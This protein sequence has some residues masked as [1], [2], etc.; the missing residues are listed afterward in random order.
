MHRLSLI[1]AGIRR[2]LTTRALALLAGAVLMTFV[3]GSAEAGD[4]S[5]RRIIGFS[6][7]GAYFAFEQYGVLDGADAHP[8]W[9]EIAVIDTQ[10][11]EVVG[12]KPIAVIDEKN[13]VKQARA[14]AAAQAAPLLAK[15]AI[16]L[17]GV[18]IERDRFTLPDD[19]IT[20]E[21]VARVETASERLLGAIQLE[22]ILAD[23]AKDCSA[24]FGDKAPPGDKKGKALGFRLSVEDKDGK[25]LKILREDKSVPEALNCPTSYSLS[26]AYQFK[27]NGK[28]AVLAVLVQSF[29]KGY[30]GPD[31]RFIAVVGQIPDEAI[32]ANKEP[33]VRLARTPRRVRR[34]RLPHRRAKVRR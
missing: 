3:A 22:E 20:R 7:D 31:R 28:P 34:A 25:P 26:E 27:P 15:Y 33:S 32:S 23:S 18:R 17:R 8:G 29:S 24:S 6:P 14:Q 16:A 19:M 1:R 13:G 5:A 4:A 11:S 2:T 9:S 30:Q 12:G 21:N 10:T